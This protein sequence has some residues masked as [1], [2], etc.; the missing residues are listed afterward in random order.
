ML[1]ANL[2]S[3]SDALKSIWYVS[4]GIILWTEFI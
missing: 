3:D 1:F 4:Y 2:L